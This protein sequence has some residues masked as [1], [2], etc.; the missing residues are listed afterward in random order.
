MSV[1]L[2]SSIS[3]SCIGLSGTLSFVALGYS[4]LID[5]E[6]IK[7]KVFA[8][9]GDVDASAF[10]TASLD[11]SVHVVVVDCSAVLFVL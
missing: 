1:K 11:V 6:V 8:K 7:G 9:V 10:S 2:L 4:T 5:S 3:N